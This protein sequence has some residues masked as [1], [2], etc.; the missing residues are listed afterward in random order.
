MRTQEDKKKER[1]EL[2]DWKKPNIEILKK[3]KTESGITNN[4]DEG[5]FYPDGSPA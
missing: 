5:G 3:D 2:K 4:Y 1:K